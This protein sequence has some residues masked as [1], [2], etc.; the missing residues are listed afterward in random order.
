M[1]WVLYQLYAYNEAT[2][3]ATL[4]RIGYPGASVGVAVGVPVGAWQKKERRGGEEQGMGSRVTST[5]N[6]RRLLV[7]HL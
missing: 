6:A 5:I 2:L 1:D 3:A 4:P 7:T